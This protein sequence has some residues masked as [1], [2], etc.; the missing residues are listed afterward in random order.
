MATGLSQQ[1]SLEDNID[2]GRISAAECHAFTVESDIDTQLSALLDWS[3]T[4]LFHVAQQSYI[5]FE[6]HSGS[7]SSYNNNNNNN[8]D[9][10]SSNS[11]YESH[12]IDLATWMDT[13]AFIKGLATPNCTR[14]E[15]PQQVIRSSRALQ[16]YLTINVDDFTAATGYEL[17]QQEEEEEEFGPPYLYHGPVCAMGVDA[18]KRITNGVFLDSSCTILAPKLMYDY[19]YY[20]HE[21]EE[22][23]ATLDANWYEPSA[24]SLIA[25]QTKKTMSCKVRRTCVKK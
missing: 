22:E 25:S 3:H 19:Y 5:F 2:Y 11:Y 13:I 10:D 24:L 4:D 23:D 6:Y 16:N 12:M 7:S 20:Y 9:D 17:Q 8:N 21:E 14:I 1:R 15:D 18:P